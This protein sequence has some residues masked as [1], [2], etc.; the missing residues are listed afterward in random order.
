MSQPRQNVGYVSKDR[1]ALIYCVGFC[2][3]YVIFGVFDTRSEIMVTLST[4]FEM[5]FDCPD[6]LFYDKTNIH[7]LFYETS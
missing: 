5:L 3:G 6:S 7:T 4:V 2:D 1:F